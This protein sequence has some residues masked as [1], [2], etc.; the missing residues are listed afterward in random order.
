MDYI[1]HC[2]TLECEKLEPEKGIQ[3][4]KRYIN[5]VSFFYLFHSCYLYWSI[6]RGWVSIFNICIFVFSKW[7]YPKILEW[8]ET[9]THFEKIWCNLLLGVWVYSLSSSFDR[10]YY[11][12]TPIEGIAEQLLLPTICIR[13]S[14]TKSAELFL[15]GSNKS[16]RIVWC[17]QVGMLESLLRN[18]IT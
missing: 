3:G 6:L 17:F 4:K 18:A 16:E 8:H 5:L 12:N 9:H 10:F 13:A 1:V 11:R 15:F 14:T 7:I 2:T